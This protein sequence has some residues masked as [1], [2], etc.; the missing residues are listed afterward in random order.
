MCTGDTWDIHIRDL[1]LFT[2]H[3]RL[4]LGTESLDLGLSRYC[5]YKF[6][7]HFSCAFPC[8]SLSQIWSGMAMWNM[9]ALTLFCMERIMTTPLFEALWDIEYLL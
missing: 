1:S 6:S 8:E 9:G 3:P 5:F 7:I 2:I 4:A